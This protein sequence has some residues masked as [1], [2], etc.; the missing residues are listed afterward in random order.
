MEKFTAWMEEHF[1]PV[2]TKI[3]T[4]KFLVAIRDAFIGIMP[5]TMA[6]AIATL[7]NVFVRDLP[8]SYVPDLG[9]AEAMSWLIGINGNVWWGTLAMI[10]LV[11]V[12]ALGY[13]VA[14]AYDVNELA[15]GVV[16]IASYIALTPQGVEGTWGNLPWGYLS[17][18]GLFTGLIVG[19]VAAV[20][21]SKLM[22]K[23]V[24]IKLPDSVPPMISN[25]FAAIVPGTIAIYVCGAI[26][27]A[28]TT[29]VGMPV[30]DIVST[31]IQT[32]FM[33]LSQGLGAILI[34]IIAVQL[35]WFFGIHG[36]NV[37]GAVLDGT[38]KTALLDNAAAFEAGKEMSYI[39]TRGSF[40]AYVWMG[41]AGCTIALIIAIYI[42]SKRAESKAV[43][44][45]SVAMGIFNI[46]EPVVFGMPIVLNPMY[47]IPWMIV[48]VIL[49]II[50]WAATVSGLV[51][52][53]YVEIPWVVPPVIY[54]FLATGG[55]FTAALVAIVNLAIA[56]VI[57]GVFVVLAN[58]GSEEA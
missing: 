21:Y 34:V 1:V 49:T 48:P 37:L 2:A 24:T 4:Q 27:W 18:T 54:A 47:F 53:V 46:N 39:W 36:T 30:G 42:F 14:K 28:A 41:G 52:P 6:G 23:N 50:G 15:G 10:T 29:F 31:Y 17:A 40:D 25:A 35:F 7:L 16:A 33:N 22:V 5:V 51:P 44:N 38:Y 9:I 56:I 3:S 8:N 45:L 12:F 55:S 43:A 11:F 26:G 13:N 58:K 57:W 32:P 19:L 20:I